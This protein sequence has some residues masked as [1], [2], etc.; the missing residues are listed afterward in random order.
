MWRSIGFASWQVR[1]ILWMLKLSKMQVYHEHM[2]ESTRL[3][4]NKQRKKLA[5]GMHILAVPSAIF[6]Y[7]TFLFVEDINCWYG[8]FCTVFSCITICTNLFEAFAMW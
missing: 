2:R 4:H 3:N 7:R 6:C 5:K 1:L 8:L